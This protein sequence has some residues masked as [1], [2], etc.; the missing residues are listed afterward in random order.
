MWDKDLIP[1][2]SRR[3]TQPTSSWSLSIRVRTFLATLSSSPG[4]RGG[5]IFGHWAKK[6]NPNEGNHQSVGRKETK[7]EGELLTS[8][9]IVEGAHTRRENEEEEENEEEDDDE[10]KRKN[11]N[12]PGK[13]KE[14]E[15]YTSLPGFG[16]VCVY[17]QRERKE[18]G[19]DPLVRGGD[20]EEERDTRNVFLKKETTVGRSVVVS[21][22]LLAS[23]KNG[24][25]ELRA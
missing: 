22:W 23:R 24:T 12:I 7:R 10:W 8:R 18:R 14:R 13:E 2:V 25:A 21:W 4:R 1:N 19:N 11:T 20:W 5:E 6:K 9:S 15:R 17:V 3:A 16:C